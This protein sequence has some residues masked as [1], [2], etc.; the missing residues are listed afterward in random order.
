MFKLLTRMSYK[1]KVTA[2]LFLLS[3]SINSVIGLLIALKYGIALPY[4][5]FWFIGLFYVFTIIIYFYGENFSLKYIL[6][7]YTI[8]IVCVFAIRFGIF[9]GDSQAEM[10]IVQG[11]LQKGFI[12]QSGLPYSP[13]QFPLLYL[14]IAL[15]GTIIGYNALNICDLVIWIPSLFTIITTIFIYIAIKKYLSNTITAFLGSLLWISLPFVSR[16]GIQ[17]TRTGMALLFLSI[18]CYLIIKAYQE[19]RSVSLTILM[20]VVTIAMISSHPVVSLFFVLSLICAFIYDNVRVS[21]RL[22]LV[23]YSPPLSN[24]NKYFYI[25]IIF[26]IT[27]YIYCTGVLYPATST[28]NQF[29]LSMKSFFVYSILG[30][31]LKGSAEGSYAVA[32]T[33]EKLFG[34]IRV[35]IFLMITA[36]GLAY[37]ILDKKF[38]SIII[39]LSIWGIIYVFINFAMSFSSTI[40]YRAIVFSSFWL[41]IPAAYWINRFISDKNDIRKYICIILLCIVILPSPFF[42]G[43]VV[44]PSDWI[45]SKDPSKAINYYEGE[46]QRFTE[47]YHRDVP[48]WLSKFTPKDSLIWSDGEYSVEFINGYGERNATFKMAGIYDTMNNTIYISNLEKLGVNYV[49]INALMRKVTI[50]P[51]GGFYPNINYSIL[52]KSKN[53]CKIYDSSDANVYKISG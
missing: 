39:P 40:Y 25:S 48:I 1:E 10:A 33:T 27:Y 19:I 47:H 31:M 26:L 37:L 7:L 3:L 32:S 29:Y 50:V 14:L 51:Y 45:Y 8:L 4:S 46:V 12:G 16:W 42:T 9:Q 30:E 28:I 53:S 17:F 5:Y 38:K 52:D 49:F 36:M 6:T 24:L 34:I 43:E 11:V 22:N 15:I 2:N 41:I 35:I 13:Q 44:L 18:S 21:F 20:L 23:D